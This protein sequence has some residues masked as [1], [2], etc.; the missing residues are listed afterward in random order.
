MN[1]NPLN[2]LIE[3]KTNP[4]IFSMIDENTLQRKLEFSLNDTLKSSESFPA[5][6]KSKLL[7][8]LSLVSDELNEQ[9]QN[10]QQKFSED[11]I[12]LA[13]TYLYIELSQDEVKFH[14]ITFDD[15]VNFKKAYVRLETVI[16]DGSDPN[17][18]KVSICIF[19]NENYLFCV[20]CTL[21]K[22][23]IYFF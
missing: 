15:F 16:P 17:T 12:P 13:S 9:N 5:E 7:H 20:L 1:P 14:E 8:Y 4:E 21:P 22:V 23:K 6:N 18:V 19:W 10:E 11:P 3:T 2:F